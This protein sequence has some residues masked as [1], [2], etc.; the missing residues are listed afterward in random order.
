MASKELMDVRLDNDATSFAAC[1][2]A[3]EKL[4][5]KA[6]P[7]RA[8]APDLLLDIACVERCDDTTLILISLKSNT[9]YLP[10]TY[11]SNTY[12]TRRFDP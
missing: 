3:P 9:D 4:G 1:V 5:T 8:D 12:L 2:W 7:A 11:I 10:W 6:A